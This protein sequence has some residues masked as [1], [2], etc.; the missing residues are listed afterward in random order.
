MDQA[1]NSQ[2]TNGAERP[3][4]ERDE[5]DMFAQSKIESVEDLLRLARRLISKEQR[6]EVWIGPTLVGIVSSDMADDPSA[7]STL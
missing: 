4:T 3:A 2:P 1:P 6:A 7:V 5:Q